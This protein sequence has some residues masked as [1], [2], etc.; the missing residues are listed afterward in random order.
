MI[1][2]EYQV[3]FDECFAKQYTM[4]HRLETNKLRNIAKVGVRV[5][6]RVRVT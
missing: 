3:C 4:I 1:K 6:V 2:N 5:R